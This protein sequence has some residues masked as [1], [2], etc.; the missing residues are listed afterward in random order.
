M[1]ACLDRERYATVAVGVMERAALLCCSLGQV[2]AGHGPQILRALCSGSHG[3]KRDDPASELA[4]TEENGLAAAPAQLAYSGSWAATKAGA[5]R[6]AFVG[7]I[8][9]ASVYR[10]VERTRKRPTPLPP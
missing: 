4:G 8:S 10:D 3:R 2:A 9:E 6:G 7:K 5:T 1:A